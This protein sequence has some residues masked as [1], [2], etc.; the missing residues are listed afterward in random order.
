MAWRG[1]SASKAHR[2]E[3]RSFMQRVPLAR[4]EDNGVCVMF[5]TSAL[6]R[7]L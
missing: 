2:P 7:H 4:H 1:A 5:S 3:V 6:R